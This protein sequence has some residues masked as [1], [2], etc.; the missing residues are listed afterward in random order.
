MSAFSYGAKAF[1]K[2]HTIFAQYMA[3]NQTF[4][5]AYMIPVKRGSTFISQFKYDASQQKPTAIIGF[6]QKYQSS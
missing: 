4:N 5:L 1:Y 3:M 2:N 6:K